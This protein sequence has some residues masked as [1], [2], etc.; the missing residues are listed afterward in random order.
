MCNI[1]KMYNISTLY[2]C[3]IVQPPS[4]INSHKEVSSKAIRPKKE[5]TAQSMQVTRSGRA[6]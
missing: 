5:A 3:V 1:G 2:N 6:I 4:T